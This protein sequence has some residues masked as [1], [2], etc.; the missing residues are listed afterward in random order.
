MLQDP[1]GMSI[2][3]SNFIGKVF[4]GSEGHL[5]DKPTSPFKASLVCLHR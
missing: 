3:L 1:R 4:L 5:E 2:I